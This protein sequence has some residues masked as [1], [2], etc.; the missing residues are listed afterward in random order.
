MLKKKKEGGEEE[1]EFDGVFLQTQKQRKIKDVCNG[2]FL[3]RTQISLKGKL[4][5]KFTSSSSSLTFKFCKPS[6]SPSQFDFCLH[7]CLQHAFFI[8]FN[9]RSSSSSTCVRRRPNPILFEIALIEE[10]IWRRR[11]D[12]RRFGDNWYVKLLGFLKP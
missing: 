2:V 8:V 5:F 7:R 9:L 3:Q 4:F 6:V 11:R 1:D 10:D 12:R